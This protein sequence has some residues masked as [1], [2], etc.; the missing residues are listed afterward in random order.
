MQVQVQV[1]VQVPVQVGIKSGWVEASGV[2]V[3]QRETFLAEP[4]HSTAPGCAA[5]RRGPA[6]TVLW[7]L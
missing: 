3:Q 4:L 1:Q 6:G 5:L 2:E 7:Y